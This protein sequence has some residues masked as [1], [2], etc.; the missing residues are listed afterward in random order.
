MYAFALVVLRSL[1]RRQHLFRLPALRS[2]FFPN[3]AQRLL[4]PKPEVRNLSL[5]RPVGLGDEL[6]PP[7]EIKRMPHLFPVLRQ[8]GTCCRF[9]VPSSHPIS[10][11]MVYR[12][13]RPKHVTQL[14]SPRT[15]VSTPTIRITS[16]VTTLNPKPLLL[17]CIS[18]HGGCGLRLP[19]VIAGFRLGSL[20][21]K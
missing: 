1:A 2:A 12:H 15:V 5:H 17:A 7:E 20:L 4:P 14:F 19:C 11:H 6:H 13:K 9:R 3:G 16:I 21:S 18:S 8:A 10:Y